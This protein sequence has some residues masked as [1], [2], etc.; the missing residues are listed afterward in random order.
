MKTKKQLYD[1]LERWAS[2]YGLKDEP[3][4]EDLDEAY[5]KFKKILKQFRTRKPRPTPDK[6]AKI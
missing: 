4:I 2:S 5:G 6:E 1:M 3:E